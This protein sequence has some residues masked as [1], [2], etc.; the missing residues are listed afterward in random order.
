[1]CVCVSMC[2]VMILMAMRMMMK[3]VIVCC[4]VSIVISTIISISIITTHTP[5]QKVSVDRAGKDEMHQTSVVYKN[6]NPVCSQYIVGSWYCM[7]HKSSWCVLPH[8]F[9]SSNVG[10]SMDGWANEWVD[11]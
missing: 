8:E 4:K 1:V 7:P 9:C 6:L 11:V 10:G 3:S 5:L 2:A